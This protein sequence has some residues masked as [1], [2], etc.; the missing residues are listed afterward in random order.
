MV[1]SSLVR[2][3]ESLMHKRIRFIRNET[4]YEEEDLET[5]NASLASSPALSGTVSL[6]C[7]IVNSIV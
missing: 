7:S 2:R 1:E 6:H 3:N 4:I 5:N